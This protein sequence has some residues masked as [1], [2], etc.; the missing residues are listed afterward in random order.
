MRRKAGGYAHAKQFKRL[1]G[2]VKRQR[3][4]LGVVLREIARKLPQA[5][6]ASPGA[7]ENQTTLMQRAGRIATQQRKDKNKLYALH[8]PEVECISKGKALKPLRV[9]GQG[10]PRSD[11]Q[12]RLDGR[13]A[14]LLPGQPLRRAH[15][16]SAKEQTTIL[17]E[18][19]GVTKQVP[20]L[21]AAGDRRQG[22][23]AALLVPISLLDEN[24][25]VADAQR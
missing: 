1:L 9:R 6:G 4:I 2:V 12:E 22:A 20:A 8:A 10:Q 16:R 11:A 18:D 14:Q 5:T 17:L 13:S 23:Q 7:R 21:A 24:D 15:P 3:T 19:V 25:T